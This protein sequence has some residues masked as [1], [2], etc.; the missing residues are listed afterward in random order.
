MSMP[1]ISH[2]FDSSPL[3]LL[4]GERKKPYLVHASL[5]ASNSKTFRAMCEGDWAE[6]HSR[7]VDWSEWEESTVK[8]YLEWIYTGDYSVSEC[9][10]I[11]R[12]P[13]AEAESRTEPEPT[14]QSSQ[15]DTLRPLTPLSACYTPLP[16]SWPNDTSLDKFDLSTISMAHAKLY[17]LAQYT[18]TPSLENA[19]LGRLHNILLQFVP[20][21]DA[22]VVESVVKLVVYVYEHTNALVNSEEPMRRVIST[23]CAVQFFEL[24]GQPAFQKLQY[25]GGD[26]MVD[27]WEKTGRF[28]EGE[29]KKSDEA[30]EARGKANKELEVKC[31]SLGRENT[32][33]NKEMEELRRKNTSLEVQYG[34]LFRQN[35]ALNKEMEELR[36]K[37]SELMIPLSPIIRPIRRR[38]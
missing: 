33:L 9:S 24:L 36:R 14:V 26:F 11:S 37:Y 8:R 4:V 35:T 1:H 2:H 30:I 25:E 29:R 13:P 18:N 12:T 15:L 22:Q 7:E 10:G 23:F 27:F 38:D 31:S 20:S 17:V 5:L 32:A 34:S 21:K 28:I 6:T 19:A 3:T 16:T